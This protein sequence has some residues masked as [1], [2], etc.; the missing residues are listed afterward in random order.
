M[1]ASKKQR[2]NATRSG[3]SVETDCGLDN[4]DSSP[5][6]V[7]SSALI[8]LDPPEEVVKEEATTESSVEEDGG[9]RDEEDSKPSPVSSSALI[10]SYPDQEVVQEESTTPDEIPSGWVRVKLEPDC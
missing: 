9:D 6:S 2:G 3:S 5:S 4:E 1:A 10:G 7:T 8:G